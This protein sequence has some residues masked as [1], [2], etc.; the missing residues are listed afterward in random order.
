MKYSRIALLSLAS[1]SAFAKCPDISGTYDLET[2]AKYCQVK[3]GGP[4]EISIDYMVGDD[5]PLYTVLPD[6]QGSV[7]Y[8]EPGLE[9]RVK[10]AADCKSFTLTFPENSYDGHKFKDLIFKNTS[11]SNQ[12]L[13]SQSEDILDEDNK[14]KFLERKSLTLKSKGRNL[15]LNMRVDYLRQNKRNLKTTVLRFEDYSCE[16][17]PKN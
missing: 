16:F 11:L 14:L 3:T 15:V 8:I 1:L 12:A 10:T 17:L 9:L 6:H 4:L 5:S 13:S 7:G 2:M